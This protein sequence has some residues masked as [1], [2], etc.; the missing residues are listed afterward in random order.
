MG[1]KGYE[2]SNAPPG[3]ATQISF[4]TREVAINTDTAQAT[5]ILIY[6]QLRGQE[7]Q[8]AW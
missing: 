8:K 7:G 1:S 5:A 4:Q 6:E 2:W 3:R